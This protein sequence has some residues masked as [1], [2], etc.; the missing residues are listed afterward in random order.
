MP[1]DSFGSGDMAEQPLCSSVKVKGFIGIFSGIFFAFSGVCVSVYSR[2]R[3]CMC[4]YMRVC[5]RAPACEYPY[6]SS[7]KLKLGE[8]RVKDLSV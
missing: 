5:Q 1:A 8:S 3:V 4:V 6:L 2:T 7:L